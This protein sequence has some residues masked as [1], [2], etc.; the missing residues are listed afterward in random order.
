MIFVCLILFHIFHERLI[1]KNKYLN[2]IALKIH[3][4]THILFVLFFLRG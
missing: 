3:I 4:N 2:E 1:P